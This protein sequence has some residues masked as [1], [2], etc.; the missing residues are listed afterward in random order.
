VAPD[1]WRRGVTEVFR[2]G[3]VVRRKNGDPFQI[4]FFA[5]PTTSD[6]SKLALVR[7]YAD[8][9]R[10]IVDFACSAAGMDW[11]FFDCD[12]LDLVLDQASVSP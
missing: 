7:G 6:V 11:G 5:R 3:N 4:I 8:D 10:V 1:A 12:E 9:G 2:P